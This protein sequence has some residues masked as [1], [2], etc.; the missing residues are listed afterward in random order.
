[1]EHTHEDEQKQEQC[2]PDQETVKEIET[3][4]KREEK[5]S[6]MLPA[7]I[8]FAAVMISGAFIYSTG[9]KQ[10][11]QKPTEQKPVVTA[12]PI[13]DR[14]VVLGNA[15]APMTI[16]EYGDFQCPGCVAFFM[17]GEPL[18]K[19]ELV[20]TGKAKLVFRPFPIVDQIVGKGT[21]S[22]DAA[23]ALLCAQDQGKFWEMH[24]GLYTAEAND[25]KAV[26]R[27]GTGSSEGNGNLNKTLFMK[28][29]KEIGTN[30]TAFASCYDSRAHKADI[31]EI[32]QQGHTAGVQG[33]PS[34]FVNGKLLE[35]DPRQYP[36][37]DAVV[38]YLKE[39]VK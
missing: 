20:E 18:I 13:T 8:V 1:M 32:V 15:N 12:P 36:T 29:A 33:T 35:L 30:T 17:A 34:I 21:E 38:K 9:A 25:E 14:D 7:S 22:I 6:W 4:I 39:E 3:I 19:K 28:I 2:A 16:I 26:A 11:A 31:D 27:A 10:A 37:W 24:E 5:S 23:M